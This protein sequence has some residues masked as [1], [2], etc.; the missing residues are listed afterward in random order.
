M[1][2]DHSMGIGTR[3]GIIGG[4]LLSI[5]VNIS[6]GDLIS[7]AVLAA[8]GAVVSFFVSIILKWLIKQIKRGG[9]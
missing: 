6:S 2:T 3:A 5:M 4:T 7:T 8:L 1:M 9:D